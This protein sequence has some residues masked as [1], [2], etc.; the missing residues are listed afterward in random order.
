MRRRDFISLISGVASW[1]LVGHAQQAAIP[2]IGFIG[3]ESPGPYADRLAAFRQGLKETG[4]VEG[5][6][7]MVEYRWAQSQYDRLPE[8]TA[9]LVSRQVAVIA[10]TGGEP[11]PQVAK[12]ATQTIPIVFTA[13][14]DPVR[15]GL[16]V[17]LN[18]PGGNATGITIFGAAAV[19]KR[20]QLMHELLPQVAAIAYLT[21]TSNPNSN[22]E[23]AAAKEAAQSLGIEL[24]VYSASNER[25]ID[26][27]FAVMAQRQ[28]RA[29]VIGADSFFYFKRDRLISLTERNGMAAIY[30]LTGFAR[31][32]GLIGYGNSLTDIFRLVG[33]Y[34]G[35]ILKGEKPA[36]LP[37]IQS[38]KFDLVI[39]LKTAK[40]L[41]LA[42]PFG[43]LNAADEV[44]E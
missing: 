8:L 36:D 31:D 6:N 14:G 9:E 37:V 44:I 24:L 2:V 43:L 30:Y 18:R 21:N 4:F 22:V 34:V 41:G 26:A 20:L 3:G 5:R 39:N 32:G 23:T 16:V 27:A 35:R 33:V 15:S 38:S 19:A 25:E 1:P 29:V 12:A 17:S 42:V 13:N 7:V 11:A 10:A 40:S 28:L